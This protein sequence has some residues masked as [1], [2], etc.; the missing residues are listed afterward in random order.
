MA[1]LTLSVDAAGSTDPDG[2]IVSY[3]WNWGD[4]ATGA[5]K[6]ASHSFAVAGT[7]QV[8]LTVTDDRGAQT[9]TTTTVTATTPAPA[10]GKLL[11]KHGWDVPWP[12]FVKANVASMEKMPFD[13]LTVAMS[14]GLGSKV[15]SQTPVSYEA[16]SAELAPMAETKFTTLR[17]NFVMAYSAPA[18]DLFGDWTVPLSNFTNLAR[19]AN[20][21]GL[22]G[23]F[24]DTEEYFGAG[25]QYPSNCAGRTVAECQAQAQLRGRQV[26][27]AMRGVWPEVRVL[28]SY[29]AWLSD[30][31]TAANLPGVPYNDVAWANQ[32]MGSFLIGMAGSAAGT[33]ARV[34]DGGEIYTP[35]TQSQFATVKAWQKQG[36][37][38]KS[39]LIPSSLKPQWAATVSAGFGVYDMPWQGVGMDVATWQTTLANA[40]ATA[41]EYVWTYTE[42]HD[43]WGSGWPTT[44][45][46]PEWVEATRAARR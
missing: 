26:M 35:R 7:Y 33:A 19:A 11:I 1:G 45:V 17:H 4:K 15:Q 39:T 38:A 42:R 40:L 44:P 31:G 46:P 30:P 10:G 23:V 29:G 8:S 32:L 14:N 2:T 21:A 25:M 27:D 16:F 9:A 5:G 6:A 12:G 24:Y 41:D 18:G 37:A 43:W 20:G 36:M 34:I 28:T 13:G 22:T 3:A